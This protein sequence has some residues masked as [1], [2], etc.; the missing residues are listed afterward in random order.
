MTKKKIRHVETLDVIIWTEGITD[1]RHLGKAAEKLGIKLK[2]EFKEAIESGNDVL[3]KKCKVFSESPQNVPM[4][5]IFDPDDKDILKNVS[6]EPNK[7]KSWGN[8]VFSFGLPIPQHRKDFKNVCIELYYTDEDIET[9][10]RNGRRL[11]LTSEFNPVSGTCLH[12]PMIHIGNIHRLKGATTAS[13]AK[14]V[15]ADVFREDENIALPKADFADYVY[16]DVSPFHHFDMHEF[17]AIFELIET[18]LEKAEPKI[19]LGLPDL[20]EFFKAAEQMRPP[21]QLSGILETMTNILEL[22]LEVFIVCTIRVYE[23]LIIN[24]PTELSKKTKGITKLLLEKYRFPSLSTV[25]ELARHCYYLIDSGAPDELLAMKDCLSKRFILGDLGNCFDDLEI[26]F[27][28][29]SAKGRLVQKAQTSKVFFDFIIPEVAK[30]SARLDSLK[31]ELEDM[32]PAFLTTLSI[33]RWQ[34]ALRTLM[35]M[36]RPLFDQVFVHSKIESTDTANRQYIIDVR[37]YVKGM[38]EISKK[39]ISFDELEDYEPNTYSLLMNDGNDKKAINLSPFLAIKDDRL[40]YYKKTTQ[41]GYLYYSALESQPVYLLETKTKFNHS[42]FRTASRG[43]QQ[44]LFWTE[45]I[46]SLNE[47]NGV[48]ANIPSEGNVDF[49][50]R[51]RQLAKVRQEIIEIPNQNGIIYGL[52]GVGKTALMIQL[53]TELFNEKDIIFKNIVWITAKTN[54][55]NPTLDLVKPEDKQFESLDSIMSTI[56]NFFEFENIEEY[57]FED[58]KD[59]FLELLRD[60]NIL[61]VL[62]NFETI[63]KREAEEIVRFF[64][65]E[66]KHWIRKCPQNFKAII[67]SRKQIPSG[68]HQIELTGLD[69]KESKLLMTRLFKHYEGNNPDLTDDQKNILHQATFGIPVLIK[70]CLGQI[71]EYNRPF[72]SVIKSLNSAQPNRAVEFS[73]AEVFKLAKEDNYKL[74]IILLLELIGCPLL[75]RQIAEILEITEFEIESKIPSLVNFQ[76]IERTNYGRDEKYSVNDEVRLFTRR[77]LQDNKVLTEEVRQKIIRNF[78]L[79]KQMDYTTEEQVTVSIFNDY[80]SGGRLLEA[81]TF[82][83]EQL[84]KKPDS[85]LLKFHYSKYLKEQRGNVEKAIQTLENVQRSGS[86]HPSILRFLISCYL[87]MKIPNYNEAYV[88]V[89]QLQEMNIEDESLILELAEY[90]VR[91]AT[92]VQMNRPTNPDPLKERLRQQHYKELADK[93]LSLLDKVKNRTHFVYYLLAQSYYNKWDG[94]NS[95]KMIE[96]AIQLCERDPAYYTTYLNLRKVIKNR[97]ARYA[98]SRG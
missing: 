43:A 59:L 19:N 18:I 86:Y 5:F 78:T 13:N 85:I 91:W 82:M 92:F 48:R 34:N 90:Y 58:K 31:Q 96:T 71:Y 98:D 60:N 49:V 10:D 36:A 88:Y 24:P 81:E 94:K 47:M 2:I 74:E 27:P 15:D 76:C 29:D 45:V 87:A 11:F 95:W 62:D 67:T 8:N 63:S 26:I 68:F 53:S 56:L 80:V 61:L 70:H 55:Y 57:G 79:E 72:D 97:Y 69:P 89:Q 3:L 84:D 17:K 77:L 7:Y 37:E 83:V 12:D 21:E 42:V 38:V 44:A 22:A 20:D 9:I 16:N 30:Y 35:D 33:A 64:E 52:G 39:S 40:F 65:V 32:D 25:H 50:G 41:R 93:A 28:P 73:Y 23:N 54:Y 6:D 66:V 75:I 46:P 51:K 4:V 1:A 14:I